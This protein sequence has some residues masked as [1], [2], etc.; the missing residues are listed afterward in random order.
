M[1]GGSRGIGA[2]TAI[3]LARR[4]YL[5]ACLSRSGEI[6]EGAG[7]GRNL[8]GY[9]CDVT[10]A[11]VVHDTV[12]AFANLA[13]G[14]HGLVNGAGIHEEMPAETVKLEQ[15]RSLFETNVLSALTVAQAVYPYMKGKGGIIIAIGSFFD[16][17]GVPGNL[18]YS[19]S[20]AA[21]ASLHR[22]LSIEWAADDISVATVAPGFVLTDLNRAAFADPTAR[23]RL[24]R[25]IPIGRLGEATEIGRLVAA[26][27]ENRVAFLT[28][29]TLYVDGGHGIR[30]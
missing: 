23:S 7:A 12:D 1:T 19:A 8:I 14:I 28:G 16:K 15:V 4:G 27:L 30:L 17:L 9:S 6:P 29:E 25:R 18:A 3:E 22:T 10:D 13:G 24:E 21:L 11:R 26:L 5:V 20:K 2:A